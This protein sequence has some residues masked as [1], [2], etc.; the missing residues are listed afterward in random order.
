MAYAEGNLHGV[1][2]TWIDASLKP[3]YEHLGRVTRNKPWDE[4]IE[5]DRGPEGGQV[6]ATAAEQVTHAISPFLSFVNTFTRM[7][8]LETRSPIRITTSLRSL[9][10]VKVQYDNLY[11]RRSVWR[12]HCI[13]MLLIGP[14]NEAGGT[15]F[16]PGGTV[17]ERNGR[18]LLNHDLLDA[19]ECLLLY[20]QVR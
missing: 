10:L 19:S 1:F 5:C 8:D 3:S 6:K 20:R 13:G 9:N 18:Q 11:V 14:A 2:R 4:E 7:G 15:V 16:V 17:D 12:W